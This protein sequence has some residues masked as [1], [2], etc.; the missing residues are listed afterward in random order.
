MR[1]TTTENTSA[2]LMQT[3]HEP[4]CDDQLFSCI[5]T[6][7]KHKHVSVL[8]CFDTFPD[9]KVCFGFPVNESR[10]QS[11]QLQLQNRGEGTEEINK[12]RQD[13]RKHRNQKLTAASNVWS[14]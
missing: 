9:F 5:E 12:Q 8:G 7:D 10:V 14:V 3:C 13:H 1:V 11:V 4:I 2:A 6:I